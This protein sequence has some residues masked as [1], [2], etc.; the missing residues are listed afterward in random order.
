MVRLAR[1]EPRRT[2]LP[3]EP[4]ILWEL[5]LARAGLGGIAATEKF[6]IFGD[7]DVDDFHD[8]FRCLDAETGEQ[9]WQVERLAIGS[10]DYGNSPRTTPLIADNGRVYCLGAHGDLLCLNLTDGDVIS[11]RLYV[12]AHH[13][14]RIAVALHTELKLICAIICGRVLMGTQPA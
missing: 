8:V 4:N 3:A 14:L 10:L 11:N 6:V 5:S 1:T 9:L 2:R 7:R 12:F 13:N